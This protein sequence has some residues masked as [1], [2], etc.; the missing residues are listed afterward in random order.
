ME[1]VGHADSDDEVVVRGDLAGGEVVVFWLRD[2]IVR[3]AM[4]VNVW[5]VND[6]LRALVGRTVARDRLAEPAIPL[7]E[8]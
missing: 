1:Y 6:Q 5:D 8:L 2:G 4:N 3:A 7:E